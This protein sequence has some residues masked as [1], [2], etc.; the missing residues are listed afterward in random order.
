MKIIL[1]H[2]EKCK[3]TTASKLV[4]Q[5]V[6]GHRTYI[7][8][9]WGDTES[10]FMQVWFA[11]VPDLT[12]HDTVARS[13][14]FA[15]LD[16]RLTSFFGEAITAPVHCQRASTDGAIRFMVEFKEELEPVLNWLN[17]LNPQ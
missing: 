15:N 2:R 14:Y 5:D 9:Q 4:L 13:E 1:E 3:I 11:V 8:L 12:F 16:R 10:T 17:T 7:D 6:L